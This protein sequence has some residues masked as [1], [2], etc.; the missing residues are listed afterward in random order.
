VRVGIIPTVIVTGPVGVGKT[1]VA[2]AVA[3]LLDANGLAYALVD[4]DAL[5]ACFP[6]P[7]D[8][9]FHTA[10]GFRNLAAIWNNFRAAGAERLVL[11]DVVESADLSPYRQ[12]I[13]GADI[14]VVRLV[15]SPDSIAQ[16]LRGRE[17]GAALAWH[18]A[19]AEELASLMARV[20]VGDVVIDANEGTPAA[21][22][23]VILARIGWLPWD[24]SAGD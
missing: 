21:L 7:V 24:D 4:M 20:A 13:P 15:A 10:L 22:A 2:T 6:R 18:L 17:D 23:A 19:R 9:P 12:A 5:R 8:D 3:D 14:T 16:R 11:A 1:T